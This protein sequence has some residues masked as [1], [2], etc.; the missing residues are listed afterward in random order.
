M[1]DTLIT[2]GAR[3]AGAAGTGGRTGSGEETRAQRRAWKRARRL[4]AREFRPRR[5]LLRLA[6]ALLLAAAGGLIA[7]EVATAYLGRPARFV[8]LDR[9]TASLRDLSWYELEV[10]RGAAVL[11]VLG[12]ALLLLGFRPRRPSRMI[13]MRSTD[14]LVTAA[15]NRR[16]MRRSLVAAALDV[17]GIVRAR[18]RVGRVRGRVSVRAVTKYR[19]P[20]NLTDL[21]RAAVAARLAE[22]D[23]MDASALHVRLKW[24]KD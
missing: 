20:A 21:V 9:W 7:I 17:P 4:A 5:T 1:E 3:A 16:S 6:A 2:S 22:L 23:L 8:P 10:R 12:M 19:N 18:V 11:T 24:R 13:P 15:V 14:P